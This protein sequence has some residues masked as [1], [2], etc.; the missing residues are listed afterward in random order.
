M[1]GF[2]WT[3][4]R[5]ALI[6]G[7]PSNSTNNKGYNLIFQSIGWAMEDLVC[8]WKEEGGMFLSER[9][10]K[11]K[12][13]VCMEHRQIIKPVEEG[14]TDD[15]IIKCRC[16]QGNNLARYNTTGMIV[17]FHLCTLLPIIIYIHTVGHYFSFIVNVKF[18]VIFVY[19]FKTRLGEF[20]IHTLQ[21]LYMSMP[22]TISLISRS[23]MKSY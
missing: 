5:Q 22:T 8:V 23:W 17:H 21:P 3:K 9:Y 19:H 1:D 2:M 20:C 10:K 12:A 16:L 7:Y 4:L 15:R 18:S 11:T 14:K 6:T 13:V